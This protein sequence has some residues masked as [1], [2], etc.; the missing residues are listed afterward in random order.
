MKWTEEKDDELKKLVSEGDRYLEIAKTMGVTYR[1]I[2]NRANRLGIKTVYY[3]KTTCLNCGNLFE[4][5][6][7][8]NRKFCNNSCAAMFNNKGR[9]VTEEQK[10]KVREKLIK[11]KKEKIKEPK[12]CRFCKENEVTEKHK[13]ICNG[14][15]NK[16]YKFYKPLCV[17]D[18]NIKDCVDK[19]DLTIVNENGWYSPKNKGNNLNG[20]SKDHMY[21]VRDG[22]INNVDPEIIR[23]PA[24]CKLLLHSENN[25]KNYNSSITIEELKERIKN[26]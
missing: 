5:L 23:H 9:V 22:F 17:F 7:T 12:S 16:F 26:W 18:F 25:K 2:M 1:S 11:P 6:I 3:K 24:N 19:F 13:V 14:C 8:H 21:S 20:V 10:Q 4:G 15:K